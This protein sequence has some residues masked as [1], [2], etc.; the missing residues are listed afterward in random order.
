MAI[1]G[2]WSAFMTFGAFDFRW[3]GQTHV[4][5]RPLRGH[6]QRFGRRFFC[7]R[8]PRDCHGWTTACVTLSTP[9]SRLGMRLRMNRRDAT[10]GLSNIQDLL[11]I[12]VLRVHIGGHE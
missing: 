3:V 1:G 2:V 8:F 9:F 10:S 11:G 5:A 6:P 4:R 12:R 7:G